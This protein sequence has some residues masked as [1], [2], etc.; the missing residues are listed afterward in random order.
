MSR[1]SITKEGKA[2]FLNE[3]FFYEVQML[4]A[5]FTMLVE[6]KNKDD[7]KA[8]I[9][10]ES[11]ISHARNLVE[12]YYFDPKSGTDYARASD[13]IEN[14][15]NNRPNKTTDLNLVLSRGNK[16]I[17]HLTYKRIYGVPEEKNWNLSNIYKDL[18]VV[19]KKFLNNLEESYRTETLNSLRNQLNAVD[20]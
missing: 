12:F 1:S 14:W 15:P 13:F 9:A 8:N 20:L 2:N 18:M 17:T 6:E 7:Y 5:A 19:T 3:H 11:I 16:E 4:D 10:M